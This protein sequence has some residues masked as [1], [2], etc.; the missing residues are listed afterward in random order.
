MCGKVEFSLR[1]F[2]VCCEKLH[3]LITILISIRN[4]VD[5][6]W[7]YKFLRAYHDVSMITSNNCSSPGEV[8]ITDACLT[9]CGGICARYYFHAEFPE[10]ISIQRLRGF[11]LIVRRDNEL[12]PITHSLRAGGASAVANAGVPYRQFQRR[13]LWKS[14]SANGG[15]VDDSLISRLSMS[16]R[17]DI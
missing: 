17:I 13:R 4:F 5:I 11:R 2:F 15:N 7:W 10:F 8:F 3:L 14:V 16:K 9:G 6:Q 12:G 1:G